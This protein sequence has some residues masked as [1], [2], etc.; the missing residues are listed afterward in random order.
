MNTPFTQ[1]NFDIGALYAGNYLKADDLAGKAYPAVIAAVERVEIPEQDGS[2]RPKAALVLQGWPAKLLLNKTN[3][4]TL[5]A[6]YGR[7][8]AG[9]LGKPLEVFPATALFGGRTVPAIRV[10]IPAPLAPAAAVPGAVLPAAPPIPTAP[11]A[12][13]PA[14]P[15]AAP[16]QPGLPSLM[17][18]AEFEDDIPY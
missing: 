6:A 10:R 4:E 16:I 5:A 1:Q 13:A 17:T 18:V 15:A 9:W 7:Q 14:P 11:V 3:F 12:A 8:S 2:V